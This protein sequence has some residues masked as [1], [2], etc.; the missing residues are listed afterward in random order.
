MLSAA[1]M[2]R[3]LVIIGNVALGAV[4]SRTLK[5][6]NMSG[7]GNALDRPTTT[8]PLSPA[9]GDT[10]IIA[11]FDITGTSRVVPS[12]QGFDD[13]ADL[14]TQ[15]VALGLACSTLPA[16]Q[17]AARGHLLTLDDCWQ[18]RSLPGIACNSNKSLARASG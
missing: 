9:K 7:Q 1:N 15:G 4:I 16:F 11:A 10:D 18:A 13:V 2:I 14:K 8:S 3:V 12:L 5:A 17:I 6:S